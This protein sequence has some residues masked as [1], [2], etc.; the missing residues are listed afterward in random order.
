MTNPIRTRVALLMGASLLGAGCAT[1]RALPVSDGS[2]LITYNVAIPNPAA[3]IFEVSGTL[4]NM[5]AD[6]ITY[7]FPV[8]APGAYDIVNFGAFVSSFAAAGE[9]GAPLRVAR[10]DTNTF[11]IYGAGRHVSLSYK[12]HDI[13]SIPSS[14]WFGLSDIEQNYAFANATALFGYLEGG[15]EVPTR[16]TYQTPRGWDITVGL[17]PAETAGTY[18]ARD[19]DELADAPLQ[20]GKFQRFQFTVNGKPHVVT[21]TAPEDLDSIRARSLVK[22]T[23]TIVRLLTGFFGDM[24]YERYIFQHYLVA[25]GP[26]D[27]LFGALEHRNSSTYRMPYSRNRELGRELASVIAHEYW[28]LW[29]PKRFHVTELG[30]FDYQHPP[31]T[32]SLWFAEGLTEYYAKVLL[33]RNRLADSTEFLEQIESAMNSPLGR[34]QRKSIT[35]ISQDISTVDPMES[36]QL[37][38][39]GPIIGLLLDAE[40][41]LQTNNRRSLDD[42]MRFFNERFGR[43][44]KTF[45]DD[46]I[47]PLMEEATGAKLAD[48]YNRYI[49]GRE[50][51]PLETYL[52]KI[53]FALAP[54]TEEQSD[55]GAEM[56]DDP[57]GWRVVEVSPGGTADSSGLKAGDVIVGVSFGP[58]R[59][60][61]KDLKV[62]AS[63]FGSVLGQFPG[64]GVL[65]VV[66]N[67]AVV[68]VPL[69]IVK[70]EVKVMR[71]SVNESATG[72]AREIRDSI[73]GF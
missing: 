24:P 44:G 38:S 34:P 16:V 56:A 59:L 1:P 20:M 10:L 33:G 12:V 15:K 43:T 25:P 28:H 2:R 64:G 70:R 45:T 18:L 62:P 22:T 9:D 69:T 21:V 31:R 53:G 49:E 68:K 73:F 13:E 23:D 48:F 14:L 29:S 32:K 4:N 3:E 63:A 65:D 26:G 66:R 36:L 60:N 27:Y 71:M 51:L 6:S 40:I 11:R 47:I 17:D 54:A 50:K 57:K 41:R 30:P 72:M 19:Y 46:E 58:A 52:P 7:Y 35:E 8:W 55:L 5:A 42:A 37:Y 67:D 61:M 39:K